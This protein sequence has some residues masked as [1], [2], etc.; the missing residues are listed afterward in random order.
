MPPKKKMKTNSD[1]S[2]KHGKF[3]ASHKRVGSTPSG[4][5]KGARTKADEKSKNVS[6]A[7]RKSKAESKI[8]NKSDADNGGSR[9]RHYTP[10]RLSKSKNDDGVAARTCKS[11]E[12]STITLKTSKSKQGNCKSQK[13][14]K[15]TPTAT[16]SGKG[17]TPKGDHKN[18]A[19]G[20]AKLQ[21]GSLK[22]KGAEDV[23]GDSADTAKVT[24]KTK[25]KL[26]GSSNAQ[27][28]Y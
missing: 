6:K 11:K 13:S 24:E 8:I 7:G 9:S 28:E 4:K 27:K 2:T 21:S 14:S 20:I 1:Q 10:R 26:A 5:S 18:R 22:V 23:K 25:G 19:N 12:E 15:Y 16:S 17:K 3:D